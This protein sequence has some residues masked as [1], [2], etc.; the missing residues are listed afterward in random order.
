MVSRN[1]QPM[2]RLAAP[3]ISED[4]IAAVGRVLRTG[5]LVQGPVVAEF[6]ALVASAGGTRHAVAVSSCT[7]A[8]HLSLL[9]LGIG[10]GD[11][12]AVATYSWPATA[13]AIVVCGATPVFIDV[14]PDTFNMDPARLRDELERRPGITAVLPVHAFG[15]MA[16]MRRICAIATEAGIGVLEDA[17]CAMGACLGSKAAGAWG[18]AGC[19]SFHPRKAITTGE[20]GAIATDDDSLASSV[21]ALRNHG[22]DPTA[23]SPDFIVPGYNQRMTDIQAALGVGQLR[24][25]DALI[26]QRR[27]MALRYNEL[28]SGTDVTVP[29]ALTGTSHV[30]QSYVVLLPSEAK[31]NRGGLIAEMRRRGI[32]VNIGTHHIPLTRFYR[33]TFTY[34]PGDFPVTD[35]VAA[36]ALALPL[37]TKLDPEAQE[38]VANELAACL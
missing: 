10:D 31:S 20:G 15:G 21:R 28:L 22:Q 5:Q 17:A 18:R 27:A 34:A 29:R 19:F 4:E 26:D 8:L 24:R 23:P 16:D 25:L 3:D 7:A 30:Y 35:D 9:G 2:I 11:L 37:H 32:E 38:R 6:E 13:N 1:A 33:E 12:V 14:T 36:R